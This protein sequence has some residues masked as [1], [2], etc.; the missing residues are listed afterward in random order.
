MW[1]PCDVNDNKGPNM[2]GNGPSTQLA[3]NNIENIIVTSQVC[4]SPPP[5]HPPNL[6]QR[7]SPIVLASQKNW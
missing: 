3:H 7:G 5:G 4:V 1:L 6:L 2:L